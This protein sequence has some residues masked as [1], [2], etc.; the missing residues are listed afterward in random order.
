M[1]I[2]AAKAVYNNYTTTPYIL[3]LSGAL[4]ELNGY[5]IVGEDTTTGGLGHMN[6]V[7]AVNRW[8]LRAKAVLY[9]GACATYGGVNAIG[10]NEFHNVPQASL[11]THNGAGS[12]IGTRNTNYN[13]PK[14]VYIPGCPAHPDWI[15]LSM[16]HI[17]ERWAQTA[18]ANFL[19]PRDLYRRPTSVTIGTTTIPLFQNT[20]HSQCP[21]KSQ[22]DVGNF[23]DSVGD[24]VKCLRAVGCRGTETY[25]DCP[26]RGWNSTG[27]G[28]NGK[29]CTAP[30]IN[31]LC[32]GC[33]QPMFPAVPL[34]RQ[35]TNIT[36][37]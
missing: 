26:T 28:G 9:V 19:P 36:F 5:A 18:P 14:S 1:A 37:P 16:V 4:S 13:G 31:H 22:H 33:S 27:T 2:D 17:I 34:N 12:F 29:W 8:G 3:V 23:A 32:I 15:V 24:P 6:V 10:G 20:V 11:P 30:G 25:A 7:D 21:R 35:I